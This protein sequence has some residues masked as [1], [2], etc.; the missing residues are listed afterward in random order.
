MV[1]AARSLAE[2]VAALAVVDGP[3]AEIAAGWRL[4]IERRHQKVIDWFAPAKRAAYAAHAAICRQEQEALA[5]YREARQVLDRKLGNWS[6]ECRRVGAADNRE[7][8][9]GGTEQSDSSPGPQPEPRLSGLSFRDHWRAEV[10]DFRQLVA[11]VARNPTLLNL[12][13]PNL[14]ALNHLARAQKQALRIPGVRVW[15][16]QVVAATGRQ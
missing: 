8:D 16:G 2:K 3:T 5:P 11:A 15:C 13:E 1:S 14:A 12:I 4:E 9:E 6:A 7:Q 10:S